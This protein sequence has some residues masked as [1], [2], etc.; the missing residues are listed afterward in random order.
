MPNTV[1][2]MEEIFDKYLPK[3][4]KKEGRERGRKED[5]STCV[6]LLIY[7]QTGLPIKDCAFPFGITF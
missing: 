7:G 4:G 1:P 3:K 6:W 2:D 5:S